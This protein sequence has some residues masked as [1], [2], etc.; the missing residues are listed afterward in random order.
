ML[1]PGEKAMCLLNGEYIEVDILMLVDDV[2]LNQHLDPNYKPESYNILY[3]NAVPQPCV[4]TVKRHELIE[5]SEWVSDN[6]NKKLMD[7]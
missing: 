6:R 2:V 1:N 5:K 3:W 4:L 7:Y